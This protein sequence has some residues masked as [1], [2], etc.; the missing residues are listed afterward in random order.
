MA[1][2][3]LNV[4]QSENGDAGRGVLRSYDDEN[5]ENSNTTMPDAYSLRPNALNIQGL[6]DMSTDD[7]IEYTRH[8]VKPTDAK[9]LVLGIRP[10]IEWVNDTSANLVFEDEVTATQA[11]LNLTDESAYA[12]GLPDKS[13]LRRA[14]PLPEALLQKPAV[15]LMEDAPKDRISELY[16]RECRSTDRKERNAR[17]KSKYYLFYGDPI[18]QR[19]R[20]I[21]ERR[22]QRNRSRSPT[23]SRGSGYRERDNKPLSIKDAARRSLR[24][25]IE[26]DGDDLFPTLKPSNKSNT[27]LRSRI[28]K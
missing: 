8:Y 15:D 16:I 4:D 26:L 3:E 13:I 19:R 12:N 25:R 20:K 9:S 27:D 23:G 24:H 11:L 17:E 18:E 7:L 10:K 21:E 22:K 6:D 28:G 14:K 5:D 2:Y 1:D